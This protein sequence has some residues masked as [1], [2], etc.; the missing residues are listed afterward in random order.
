MPLSSWRGGWWERL[1]HSV[2]VG[3]RM[4]LGTICRCL[5]RTELE[6][7]LTEVDSVVNSRPVTMVS[8]GADS[9]KPLT[10]SHF[11]IGQGAGFQAKLLGDPENV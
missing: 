3:L 10:P 6:T 2:N 8:D 4:S 11:L 9:E 1:I 5:T 7:V